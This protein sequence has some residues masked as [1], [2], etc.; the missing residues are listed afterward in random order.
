MRKC[1]ILL[2]LLN[3]HVLSVQSQEAYYKVMHTGTPVK[4]DGV[5]DKAQWASVP[6]ISVKNFMGKIPEYKPDVQ[7]K[8]QYDE[9][10]IFV[11][12]KVRDK[13]ISSLVQEPNG[14]V[15][16]DACVEFFFSPEVNT[17]LN[18]F[19][20]ETNAG[21]TKLM[22]YHGEIT[23]RVEVVD[24]EE[25]V[26]AHSL[27]DVISPPIMKET[28][29]TLEYRIPFALLTKYGQV[30]TPQKGVRWRANFY[31]TAS[32]GLNPHYITW[33]VVENHKPNF[34]LPAYFGVLEFE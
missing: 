11:I 5:W 12:F 23:K 27:P 29:W 31:K 32:T 3:L 34:H 19:N 30:T 28:E 17:P 33:S 10:N 1:W 24:L 22:S 16:R 7:I 9:S 8:I 15:S 13:F 26:L 21:G 6:E 14:P 2:I 25:I 18:Y 4:I 20:F